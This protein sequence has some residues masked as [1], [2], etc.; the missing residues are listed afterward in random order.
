M[1]LLNGKA[2][3]LQLLQTKK[4]TLG[5]TGGHWVLLDHALGVGYFNTAVE[6][7]MIKYKYK[8]EALMS[9]QPQEGKL[10]LGTYKM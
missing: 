10:E 5:A 4:K 8:V 1:S 9:A 6:L 3:I 2:K 7:I